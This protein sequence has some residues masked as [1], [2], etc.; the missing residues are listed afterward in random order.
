MPLGSV[1]NAP[2][3]D[4]RYGSFIPAPYKL[5]PYNPA[6]LFLVIAILSTA[7]NFF[8]FFTSILKSLERRLAK[9]FGKMIWLE[10]DEEKDGQTCSQGGT[11]AARACE[12]KVGMEKM[13]VT[14]GSSAPMVVPRN[15]IEREWGFGRESWGPGGAAFRD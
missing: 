3:P 2:P 13:I 15:V 7:V 12:M 14:A 10:L 1:D 8:V 6:A 11:F 5:I 9:L 4:M